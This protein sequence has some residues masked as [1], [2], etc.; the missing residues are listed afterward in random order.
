MSDHL[1]PHLILPHLAQALYPHRRVI[2]VAQQF[3]PQIFHIPL[4]LHPILPFMIAT[5]TPLSF[6]VHEVL[7]LPKLVFVLTTLNVQVTRPFWLL[8]LVLMMK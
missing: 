5:E 7:R 4:P 8:R 6:G 2:V 1:R 3:L